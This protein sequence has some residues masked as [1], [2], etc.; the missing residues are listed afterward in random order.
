ME[1]IHSD[2]I[3]YQ[4]ILSEFS[5]VKVNERFEYLL[6]EMN[7]FISDIGLS[8]KAYVHQGI[9]SHVVLDYFSDIE[10]LK[11]FHK[12]ELANSYKIIAYEMSWILRR[13]PIQ[14]NAQNLNDG[15]LSNDLVY[16][17][18][19]FALSYILSYLTQKVEGNLEKNIIDKDK[20]PL[21]G[22]IDS[23]Y[24]YLKYR[25][26]SPQCLEMILLSFHAGYMCNKI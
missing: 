10:R 15:K 1:K 23:F 9:L 7:L 21:N 14:L 20:K 13:K 18:E 4:S 2:Y 16:L 11:D 6:Q 25:D 3:S 12:I 19:K 17:N 24:Y 22:F 26:C 5:D 8:E